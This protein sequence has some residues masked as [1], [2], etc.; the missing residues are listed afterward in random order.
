MVSPEVMG[1]TLHPYTVQNANW[2]GESQHPKTKKCRIN[3]TTV[4]MALAKSATG[5]FQ[6]LVL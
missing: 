3:P 2:V 5:Y 4:T 6:Q 1:S